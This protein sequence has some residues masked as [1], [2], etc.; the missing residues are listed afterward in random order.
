MERVALDPISETEDDDIR[1]V[2]QVIDDIG[3]GK[4]QLLLFF[5]CGLSWAT[6]AVEILLLSFLL[7]V[8]ER[9]W[10]LSSVSTGLLGSVTFI[11]IMVG[12]PL[13][14]WV[15][16]KYGRRWGILPTA[17]CEC[18]F[19]LGSAFSPNYYVFLICRF[20]LG[21]GMAGAPAAIILF[22]EF[23]PAKKRGKYLQIFILNWCFGTT[24][25]C[26]LAMYILP[27]LGWRYLVAFASLPCFFILL[28]F[29]L[30]PESPRYHLTL[31]KPDEALGV[32]KRI[33]NWNNT[34]IHPSTRLKKV[35]VSEDQGNIG[36]LLQKENRVMTIVFWVIWVTVNFVYYGIIFFTPEYFES[37]DNNNNDSFDFTKE[38]YIKTL[39]TTV[40]E[41][42]GLLVG[43]LLIDWVLIRILYNSHLFLLY[44]EI[45]ACRW[46]EKI[47]YQVLYFYLD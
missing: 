44:F 37:Q 21:V 16:D 34:R 26:V 38:D 8:L 40:A 41:V 12:S 25:V 6:D 35:V 15:S 14:G 36:Q 3:L 42:P 24:Y 45:N 9:D 5:V 32:L 4:A 10:E 47:W 33:A 20:F 31:G 27:T 19:A 30:I 17:I 43:A 29:P 39:I 11:G 2:D 23:L 13:W 18:L 1:T 22:Q 7:P 46:G 28:C